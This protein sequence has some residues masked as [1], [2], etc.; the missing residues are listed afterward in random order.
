MF[1]KRNMDLYQ[2]LTNQ[3]HRVHFGTPWQ[4]CDQ[5]REVIG[6]IARYLGIGIDSTEVASRGCRSV[7]TWGHRHSVK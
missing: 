1:L 4:T 6:S 2:E 3:K 7:G 5:H